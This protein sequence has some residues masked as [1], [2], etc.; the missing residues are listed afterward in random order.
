MPLTVR[1]SATVVVPLAESRVNPPEEVVTVFA[2]RLKLSTVAAQ[3]I[4]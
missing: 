4:T 2:S 1:S 3:L